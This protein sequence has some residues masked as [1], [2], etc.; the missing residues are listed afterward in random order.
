M[1]HEIFTTATNFDATESHAFASRHPKSFYL[2][3]VPMRDNQLIIWPVAGSTVHSYAFE[4]ICSKDTK[5]R[6]VVVAQLVE[7]PLLIPEVRGS[8]PVIGK[9]LFV[10]NI[11]LLST[12]D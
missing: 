12:V 10:S 2:P 6:K 11:C 4:I 1:F 5:F 7:R 3:M 9:N 8:N